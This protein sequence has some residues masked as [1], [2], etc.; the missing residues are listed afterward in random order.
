MKILV[1]GS[2][3]VERERLLVLLGDHYR[4]EGIGDNESISDALVR[5]HATMALVS[6]DEIA[7]VAS[8]VY[9]IA[10]ISETPAPAEFSR[11]LAAGADDVLRTNACKEEVWA[12]V[13]NLARM[14]PRTTP[15]PTLTMRIGEVKVWKDIERIVASELGELLGTSLNL[16]QA[17]EPAPASPRPLV[18]TSVIPLT[19]VSDH[20]LVQL[21]I[22]VDEATRDQLVEVLLGGDNSGDALRDALR[23]MANT[24]GGAIRRAALDDGVSFSIGLPSNENLFAASSH[25][26]VWTISDGNG[27]Q[28]DC[29]VALS[30]NQPLRVHATDLREGMVLARDILGHDGSILITAGTSL[31]RTTADQIRDIASDR[32][33]EVEAGISRAVS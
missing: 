21:G 15:M 30:A 33:I 8:R 23:E 6:P 29:T 3:P 13:G 25:Q 4:C 32:E 19:L 7:A 5:T 20:L 31:T 2:N 26:R 24:A 17:P 12:R 9:S 22:G 28:L 11:A 18:H 14:R 1:A 27:L 10:L 16:S